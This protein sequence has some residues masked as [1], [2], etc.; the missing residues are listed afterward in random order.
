MDIA[1]HI[2]FSK[3][4]QIFAILCL[5][6]NLFATP[7]FAHSENENSLSGQN[8]LTVISEGVSNT[9]QKTAFDHPHELKPTIPFVQEQRLRDYSTTVI[10][11]WILFSLFIIAIV[12]YLF[13]ARFKETILAVWD[14]RFFNFLE[15]E[16]GL[17]NHWVS[18]FLYIN[19]LL[20]F[21]LLIYQSIV[22][23]KIYHLIYHHGTLALLAA[24]LTVLILFFTFKYSLM[25]L[26]AWVF[27]TGNPTELYLRNIFLVNKFTGILLLPVL[28]INH[29]N[30]SG[31]ILAIAW[32]IVVLMEL[33]RFYKVAR[34]GLSMKGFSVYHLILYL[35]AVEIA[36][37]IFLIK[38]SETLIY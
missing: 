18:L 19:Y 31:Y 23:S 24:S 38:Y 5:I 3:S 16:T 9:K 13:P 2:N 36:P 30:D 12:K 6:T 22:F 34:I 10:T 20:S 25:Y 4:T 29:Y 37:V 28:T 33:F 26:A 32:G 27:K 1:K 35:C 17:L 14:S 8:H 21:S 11:F 7:L 15:R